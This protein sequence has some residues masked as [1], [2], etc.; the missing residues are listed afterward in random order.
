ME[1]L[2]N[3]SL[4]NDLRKDKE[5]PMG[6]F[7]ALLVEHD[8]V[9]REVFSNV[10]KEDGL[11]VLECSTAE[12]AELV[13][14]TSGTELQVVITDQKLEGRMSGSELAAFARQ[15]F[16]HLKIVVMSGKEAPRLPNATC[17]L[18]KPFSPSDLVRA[19]RA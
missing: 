16:P 4:K 13:V 11:E 7:M 2:S 15:R 9:Q 3:L 5:A 8:P 12:A 17:F 18:Q 14:A 6:K 10:L 19:V 1:E